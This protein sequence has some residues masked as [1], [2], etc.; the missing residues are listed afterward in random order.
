MHSERTRGVVLQVLD[1]SALEAQALEFRQKTHPD[2][3]EVRIYGGKI[4]MKEKAI[5]DADGSYTSGGHLYTICTE[6]VGPSMGVTFDD[7]LEV[8]F[9]GTYHTRSESIKEDLL[10][11]PVPGEINPNSHSFDSMPFANVTLD[12]DE[13]RSYPI[14]EEVDLADFIRSFGNRLEQNFWNWFQILS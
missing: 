8:S 14:I 4:A 2:C 11:R 10:G 7:P 12:P 1:L 5:K 6:G 3:Y 13:L 9:H